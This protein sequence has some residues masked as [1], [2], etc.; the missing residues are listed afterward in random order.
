MSTPTGR[1]AISIALTAI[2]ST[3]A[4]ER[5]WPQCKAKI[6]QAAEAGIFTTMDVTN[7]GL[8]VG[9]DPDVWRRVEYSTKMGMV[10]ALSCLI[11]K[12]GDEQTRIVILNNR[13]H[14]V[15]GEGYPANFEVHE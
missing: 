2:C 7:R 12:G 14:H 9:V 4:A 11:T 5:S 6:T 3:A 1:L 13:N 8:E 10:W 15:M